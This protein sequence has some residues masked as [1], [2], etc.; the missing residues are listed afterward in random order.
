MRKT[1]LSR[2]EDVDDLIF[3][4]ETWYHSERSDIEIDRDSESAEAPFV[5]ARRYPQIPKKRQ[6]WKGLPLSIK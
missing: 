3:L 6:A 4:D 5:S 2:R 1:A